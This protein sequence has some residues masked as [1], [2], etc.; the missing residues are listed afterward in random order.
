MSTSETCA[1]F[2][3]SRLMIL[4]CNFAIIEGTLLRAI[5]GSDWLFER[6]AKVRYF[7]NILGLL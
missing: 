2:V 4:P 7:N 5:R 1:F 3:V 6:F